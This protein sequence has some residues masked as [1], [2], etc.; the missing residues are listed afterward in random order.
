VGKIY[1]G[2]NLASEGVDERETLCGIA[3]GARFARSWQDNDKSLD[4]FD[5]KGLMESLFLRFGL[6]PQF[7]KGQDAS[8]HPNKQAE[9]LLND[10]RVGVVGELHPLVLA[11]FD[12]REPVYLLEADLQIMVLF[13]AGNKIYQPVPRFPSTTRDM[14]LIVN[15][16]VNHRKLARTIESFPLIERVEIF[17][18]Y[19]GGQVPAGKK[20]LA[21]RVSYR[22]ASHTLT[23]DEVNR[24]QEQVLNK[25]GSDFGAVLRS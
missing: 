7:R 22:S 3:G 23:D 4:F 2:R 10:K 14:A 25:L 11:A 12:I 13:T 1:L 24:V 18:V 19:S 5:A 15:L 8:L 20:S 21:Y 17:D 9:V 16:D 6:N